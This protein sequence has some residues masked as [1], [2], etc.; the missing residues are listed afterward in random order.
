M[1]KVTLRG[2]PANEFDVIMGLETV[3]A[4]VR[5]N[6]RTLESGAVV[7][8][9]YVVNK[10]NEVQRIA[11]ADFMAVDVLEGPWQQVTD[12]KQVKPRT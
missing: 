8:D 11:S 5:H 6:K 7:V 10:V 2:N 12:L 3:P 9:T 1:W 4:V